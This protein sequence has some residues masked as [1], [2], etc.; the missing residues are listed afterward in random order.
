MG[1]GFGKRGRSRRGDIRAAILALLSETPMHGY[2][3]ITE[4]Q[5]RS[6]GA[7]RPSPGSV[8]PTLQA[9]EDQGLIRTTE[10]DGKKVSEL[11]E[12]GREAA[13]EVL[14]GASMPWA[15]AAAEVGDAHFAF[16][17][18]MR[19]VGAA[20]MQVGRA[21]TARQLAEAAKVLTDTRRRL[22]RI[23]ADDEDETPTA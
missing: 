1:P 20:A 23:L 12:A 13:A 5:T 8:Y 18:L 2:Q 4:L 6:E 3:I 22:Y 16:F 17:D 11:T 14:A 15:D 19:Q 7:W 21:G 10:R 9:L